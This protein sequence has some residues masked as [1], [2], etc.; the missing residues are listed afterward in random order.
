MER[1]KLYYLDNKYIDYLRKSDTRVAFN[2][3][4]T[5]PYVGVVYSFNNFTYFAPLS[6]PKPK[7]L[8]MNARNIDIFKIKDGTLGIVNLN[9]MIPVPQESLI[10][11]ISSVTDPK[12]RAL[13]NG[14]ITELNKNRKYLFRKVEIFQKSYRNNMLPQNVFDRTCNFNLLEEK[15]LD[16]QREN[17]MATEQ[18][19]NMQNYCNKIYEKEIDNTCVSTLED[20]LEK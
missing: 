9:N 6:S 17:F 18:T 4:Q 14:Q 3:N 20:T 5:R 11:F 16:Y 15:C 7:H 8:K 12:Y 13:L 2:K 10:D 19:N 1:L